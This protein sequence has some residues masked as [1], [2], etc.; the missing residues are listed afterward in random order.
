MSNGEKKERRKVGG[1]FQLDQFGGEYQKEKKEKKKRKKRK[2]RKKI[3][4]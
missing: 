3:R 4:K 1:N 2:K